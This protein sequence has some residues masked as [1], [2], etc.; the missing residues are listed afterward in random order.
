MVAGNFHQAAEGEV[1]QQELQLRAQI[2]QSEKHQQQRDQ[3]QWPVYWLQ[4]T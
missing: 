3:R 1:I 2:Q 4:K